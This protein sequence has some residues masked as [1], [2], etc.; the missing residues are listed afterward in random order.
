MGASV[1]H[2]DEVPAEIVASVRIVSAAPLPPDQIAAAVDALVGLPNGEQLRRV[3]DVVA[4]L[5]SDGVPIAYLTGLADGGARDLEGWLEVL[6][7]HSLVTPSSG[8]DEVI[9]HQQVGRALR[10]IR[11]RDGSAATLVGDAVSLLQSA[12]PDPD[13]AHRDAWHTLG[14]QIIALRTNAVGSADPD[15]AHAL[16]KL[17]ATYMDHVAQSTDARVVRK[18]SSTYLR[19]I[20]DLVYIVHELWELSA[21]YLRHLTEIGDATRAVSLGVDVVADAERLVDADYLPARQAAADLAAAQAT[22]AGPAES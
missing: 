7:D 18:M 2:Q 5:A 14:P 11:R 16:T 19:D 13:A 17:S 12:A 9:M 8:H 3:L 1:E 15:T 20:S 22:L 21:A 4:F 10:E 6:A